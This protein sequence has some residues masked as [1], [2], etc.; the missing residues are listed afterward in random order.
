[1]YFM[2]DIWFKIA[3]LH[4]VMNASTLC[5]YII[6]CTVYIM[7]L[8]LPFFFNLGQFLIYIYNDKSIL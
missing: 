3:T 4:R 8:R 5:V 6:L 2:R 7:L 1:M